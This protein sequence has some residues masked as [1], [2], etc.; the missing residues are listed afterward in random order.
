MRIDVV[1]PWGRDADVDWRG[2]LSTPGAPGHP[3]INYWAWAA[4]SGGQFHQSPD[5]VTAEADA[6]VVLLRWRGLSNLHAVRLLKARGLTVFVSWKESGTAQIAQQLRWPWMRWLHRRVLAAAD[7]AFATTE[8]G[9][10]HYLDY[11]L[12]PDRVHFVT[13]PYPFDEPGWDFAERIETRQGL[14]VGS[15]Q[16]DVPSR[17][18]A[19]ALALA[20]RIARATGAPLSVLNLDGE[21]GR[22]RVLAAT[23]TVPELRWIEQRLPYPEF[24]RTL[25]RHRIV[26]QRDAG[27]VPGQIAG[28][29]L[30]CGLV[31]IGGNGA[32]QRLAFPALAEPEA[33][34]AMLEAAAIALLQDEAAYRHEAEQGRL[35]AARVGLGYEGFRAEL[36]ALLRAAAAAPRSPARG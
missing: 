34:E 10:A 26:I 5:T 22:D 31:N 9:I 12:A 21:A 30:L 15:R 4:A 13:T 11:G 17:R 14:I 3:P 32:V 24:L 2:G 23:G 29:A 28:D 16:F 36:P 19:E 7:G 27:W 1:N 35:R 25:A 8:P 6:V 20:G 18:H 33:D